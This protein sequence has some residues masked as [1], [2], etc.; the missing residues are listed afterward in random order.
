MAILIPKPKHKNTTLKK[1]S[2]LNK[3]DFHNDTNYNLPEQTRQTAPTAKTCNRP[4]GQCWCI[5]RTPIHS[6]ALTGRRE[7][8]HPRRERESRKR[9]QTLIATLRVFPTP[10]STITNYYLIKTNNL[11]RKVAPIKTY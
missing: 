4:P 8:K 2:N 9:H 10:S 11:T 7:Q 5:L 3:S 1:N 6:G